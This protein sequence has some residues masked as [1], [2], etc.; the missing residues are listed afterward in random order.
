MPIGNQV[1][2]E[3]ANIFYERERVLEYEVRPNETS[4]AKEEQLPTSTGV[5]VRA[6]E[7]GQRP[8]AHTTARPKLPPSP[9]D[10]MIRPL[11]QQAYIR[12][13]WLSF[14]P[15]NRYALG[16]QYFAALLARAIT[17]LPHHTYPLN[18]ENALNGSHF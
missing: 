14:S 12:N 11:H 4:C 5:L 8:I 2:R 1:Q 7:E 13:D 16:H 18:I 10:A 17:F 15:P 9:P 6:G 3:Y